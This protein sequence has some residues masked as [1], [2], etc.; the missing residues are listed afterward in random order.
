PFARIGRQY[1][2]IKSAIDEWLTKQVSG[3]TPSRSD[4][5]QV[6]NEPDPLT[7]RLLLVG[8]LTKKLE[9]QGIKPVIV[10]GQAVEFYTVG[11]Y[12]TKD[13]DLVSPRADAIGDIL[14]KWGFGKEG[15]FWFN[16][17]L[18]ISIEVPSA[19]L[20]GDMDK[21]TVVEI[22]NLKVY[23]IGIEDIIIDRMNAFVHWKSSDDRA[24]A[25]EL[26]MLNKD[27]IDWN[28][29]EKRAAEEKTLEETKKLEKEIQSS[30]DG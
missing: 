16:D 11:G 15:R 2:F 27:D 8:L 25:K 19:V 4:L 9:P 24:W 18:G 20:A 23:V 7:R 1:R 14:V 22:D 5:K 10:G 3:E 21:V 30:E 28:Y 12:A 17:D 29:L 26:M 13:I 6:K